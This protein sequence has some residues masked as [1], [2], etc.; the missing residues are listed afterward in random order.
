M[1]QLVLA[2][3]LGLAA[4]PVTAD[5]L[6][7]DFESQAATFG[8]DAGR[9]G[10]LT[11]L[12]LANGGL[13]LTITR[14]G[15]VGFDIVSNTAGQQG[16]PEGWGASSLDTFFAESS[17]TAFII[18]LSGAAE[19][20]SIQLGDYGADE[21]YWVLQAFSGADATGSLLAASTGTL[22]SG[23]GGFVMATAAV[24][25]SGITSLRLIAGSEYFAHSI[26]YDN[27]TVTTA[28]VP[29]PTTLWLLGAGLLGLAG[30]AAK[31]N[32]P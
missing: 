11:S 26:F 20:F 28:S 19:A 15:G 8:P 29:E 13:A 9:T 25:A 27:I 24:A 22:W 4:S 7:F 16:K 12:T 2:C 21:D 23:S 1:R 14:E 6:T 3:C 10:A 30:R 31:R 17:P 5:T 18:N 32:R